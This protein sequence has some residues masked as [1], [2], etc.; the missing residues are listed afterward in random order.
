MS[1]MRTIAVLLVLALVTLTCTDSSSATTPPPFDEAREQQ[2][3]ADFAERQGI[4]VEELNA[5]EAQQHRYEEIQNYIHAHP[6]LFTTT[7]FDVLPDGRYGLIV[8]Y[9]SDKLPADFPKTDE[10]IHFVKAK[11]TRDELRQMAWDNSHLL[12]DPNVV[13]IGTGSRTDGIVIYVRDIELARRTLPL[14]DT[15]FLVEDKGSNDG[16]ACNY[17][18]ENCTP[19]RGGI[20]IDATEVNKS[21]SWG[22][23]GVR[24]NGNRVMVTSAHCDYNPWGNAP[25]WSTMASPSAASNTTQSRTVTPTMSAEPA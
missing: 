16:D 9:T 13:A 6:D 8:H 14:T 24:P 2:D 17:D 7:A 1:H 3:W 12:A 5:R 10:P 18:Y 23:A 21:C 4:T 25:T 19:W 20:R 15:M 11:F 22:F